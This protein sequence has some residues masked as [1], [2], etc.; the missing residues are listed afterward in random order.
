[1]RE[2]LPR[3]RSH[4]RC[5]PQLKRRAR[6]ETMASA[7]SGILNVSNSCYI[8]AVVQC[9]MS[10]PHFSDVVLETVPRGNGKHGDLMTKAWRALWLEFGTARAIRPD[11]L[12]RAVAHVSAGGSPAFARG[13][14]EDAH[15]FLVFLMTAFHDTFKRK[16]N[17]VVSGEPTCPR[18][19]LAKK[20]YDAFSEHF[21]ND[22][23][24]VLDIFYGIQVTT[25]TD[26]STGQSISVKP[27]PVASIDLPLLDGKDCCLE[28]CI[29][30][31]CAAESI[32]DVDNGKGDRVLATRRLAYWS[33]PRILVIKLNR[34]TANYQKSACAVSAPI[35]HLDLSGYTVGY[36][37]RD[38]VYA[39]KAVCDHVGS[40]NGGHYTAT[41]LR[42]G[43]WFHCDDDI[44]RHVDV[45]R[46]ITRNTYCLFYE[47]K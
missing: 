41:V 40:T 9:L 19:R 24:E 33:L 26:D 39:L 17:M 36:R 23:S 43:C 22:F 32:E 8:N 2:R 1:M 13:Y 5:D 12:L 46:V 31:L 18:D 27:E 6:H 4:N 45:Q 14:Q 44:V 20:C 47:R 37:P 34:W 11:G 30:S 42:D 15:E 29:A 10:T 35:D 16:V 21:A 28:D 25:L 3:S 7:P 38:S